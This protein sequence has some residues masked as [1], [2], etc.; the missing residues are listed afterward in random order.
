MQAQL[1]TYKG[2]AVAESGSKAYLVMHTLTRDREG[3]LLA[4][5]Q[6]VDIT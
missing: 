5:A 1:R 2:G 4:V 6:G 3:I